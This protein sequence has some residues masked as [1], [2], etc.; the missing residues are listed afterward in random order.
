[1]NAQAP[2]PPRLIAVAGPEGGTVNEHFG[3][4]EGF[5][6]YDMGSGIPALRE[7][8]HIAALA[9]DGEDR[10]ET[11][12]RI[13]SDCQALLVARIGETPKAMMAQA[14]I[15]AT[16]DYAD[17]PILD[18][19]H[20]YVHKAA[21]L[22]PAPP[23]DWDRPSDTAAFRIIHTMLRVA[24]LERSL[25]FYTRLLGMRLIERRDHKKNQFTQAYLG[26]G[27]NSP[28]QI[29]L[30]FNW[31]RQ[32][33]YVQ[34]D[35]FG[36]FAIQVNGIGA[37]CRQLEAAGIPLPRP[38]RSQRHGNSIVAFITDPD[39]YQIELVQYPDSAL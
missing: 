34:G 27:E 1:M 20:A 4:A 37:L 32:A 15:D 23:E 24:D 28:A 19:L 5:L 6:I 18:A 35:G 9:Q 13:L 29:E 12:R 38:P 16:G 36:H 17:R 3:Q 30:V 2:L 10:R 33:P 14:G 8:R 39:G 11:I 31:D 26:Y 7:R 25:D 21:T 22:D